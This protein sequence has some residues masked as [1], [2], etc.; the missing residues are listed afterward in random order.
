MTALSGLSELRICGIGTSRNDMAAM[1][2]VKMPIFVATQVV[3][4]IVTRFRVW[5]P[6]G[7]FEIFGISSTSKTANNTPSPGLAASEYAL[8]TIRPGIV[9]VWMFDMF[10]LVRSIW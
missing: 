1:L 7:L 5:A 6:S 8:N 2:A 10:P 3:G 4:W 9:I